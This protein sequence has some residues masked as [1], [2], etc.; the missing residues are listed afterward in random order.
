MNYTDHNQFSTK[1][2]YMHLKKQLAQL[3]LNLLSTSVDLLM[4]K[5]YCIYDDLYRKEPHYNPPRASHQEQCDVL[6]QCKQGN[7][8][9]SSTSM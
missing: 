2:D 7:I 3:S 6:R 9:S 5:T 8:S 4:W 1:Y